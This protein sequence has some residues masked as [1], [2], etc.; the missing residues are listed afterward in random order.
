MLDGCISE[1][2]L[3]KACRRLAQSAATIDD[4]EGITIS[5]SNP[6]LLIITR[7]TGSSLF[8]E[9]GDEEESLDLPD[10]VLCLTWFANQLP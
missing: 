4:L 9:E 2:D 1:D 8:V 5:F 10:E 3:A 7:A 6:N